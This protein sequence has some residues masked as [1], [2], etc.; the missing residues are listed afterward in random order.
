MPGEGWP[1]RVG[2]LHR[3]TED[4]WYRSSLSTALLALPF[5][6]MKENLDN[7]SV[8]SSLRPGVQEIPACAPSPH[9]SGRL[10]HRKSP[11]SRKVPI[12]RASSNVAPSPSL[13]TLHYSGRAAA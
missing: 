5:M 7:Y 10:R 11:Q 6:P 3:A 1:G 4:F 2:C 9:K 12:D 13:Q 8:S